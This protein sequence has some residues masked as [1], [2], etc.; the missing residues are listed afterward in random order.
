MNKVMISPPY[1]L[2]NVKE[3]KEGTDFNGK[4]VEHVR[5]IVSLRSRRFIIYISNYLLFSYTGKV[6][7]L[8]AKQGSPFFSLGDF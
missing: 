7:I 1:A 3:Y 6:I 5:K 8:S 4:A 2:D